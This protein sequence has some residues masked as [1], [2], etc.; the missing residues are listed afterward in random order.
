MLQKL[1]VA[2]SKERLGRYVGAAKGDL[3][4]AIELYELNLRLS[5]GLYGVLHGYEV[6][7]R[8]SMHDQLTHYYG[9]ANWYDTAPLEQWHMAQIDE[10]ENKCKSGPVTPGKIIAELSLAFWTGL[11]AQRY[12]KNVWVPCLR[13]AFHN[14]TANRVDMHR[15]L[16]EIQDLRNRVAHHERI[17]GSKGR[18][19]IGL[20]HRTRHEC[21]IR[22]ELIFN[23]V[24]WICADTAAWVQTTARFQECLAILDSEPAKSLQI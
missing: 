17:L 9:Q 22:P 13:K 23:T 2:I 20:H 4:S 6:T 7:L 10:A 18:L 15:T 14:K 5:Q 16:Q 19:Y 3:K 24:C 1:Q 12:E 21:F 11:A 8:N